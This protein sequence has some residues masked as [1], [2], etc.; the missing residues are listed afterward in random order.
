MR[1]HL[2]LFLAVLI[3]FPAGAEERVLRVP[4]DAAVVI[5]PRGAITPPEPRL[6]SRALP[7]GEESAFI[8]ESRTPL[9]WMAL[10]ARAQAMYIATRLAALRR[11]NN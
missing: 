9:G 8:A 3:A 2:A 10:I 1:F 6:A 11:C 4:G 7:A 5:P